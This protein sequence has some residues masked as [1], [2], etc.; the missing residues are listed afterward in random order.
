ML[1]WTNLR[2]R[3]MLATQSQEAILS[4]SA[5][6]EGV[7]IGITISLIVGGYNMFSKYHNKRE[8]INHIKEVIS[9]G[10]QKIRSVE[11]IDFKGNKISAGHLRLIIFDEI[12]R[13]LESTLSY[14]SSYL[15]YKK[16]YD[17]RKILTNIS[18]MMRDLGI[19]KGQRE[20]ADVKFFEQN[21][22]D[23]F[24]ELGWLGFRK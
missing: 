6:L 17:V 14:R 4:L 18:R 10:L 12:L 20:P 15:D 9:E 24:I 1:V 7:V 22:F 2:G 13:D 19:G 23:R 16:I 21:F 8:Q 11:S 5:L 3:A